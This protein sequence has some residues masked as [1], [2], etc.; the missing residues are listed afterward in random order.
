MV[1]PVMILAGSCNFIKVRAL[2]LYSPTLA[3]SRRSCCG[4][5]ESPRLA[6]R[7]APQRLAQ[8]APPLA[9]AR[10]ARALGDYLPTL[11]LLIPTLLNI[12]GTINQNNFD[13]I[14]EIFRLLGKLY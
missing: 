3:R 9:L 14:L 11:F 6:P 1:R 2:V 4:L 13:I 8:G 10:L 5:L 12:S 7:L